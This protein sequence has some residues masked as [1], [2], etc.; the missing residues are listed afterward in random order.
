MLNRRDFIGVG[1]AALALS[2]ADA[3]L[4]AAGTIGGSAQPSNIILFVPDEMRAD[5]L[6]CYGAPIQTP[7]FDRLAAEGVRFD[8]CFVQ[9]P[10]CSQS[11]CSFLTGW[12]AS[13]HGHRSLS[14][15]LRPD[16]PNLFRYL[17]Q[18]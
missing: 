7:N 13:V 4:Q 18:N 6:H 3:A 11:R 14:Y 8:N 9:F 10:V 17:K 12:P 5:A 2:K 16:E 15:L 1:A